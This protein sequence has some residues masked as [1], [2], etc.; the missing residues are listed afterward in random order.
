M[1]KEMRDRIREIPF[2][3]MAHEEASPLP[4][5]QKQKYPPPQPQH[6]PYQIS[7]ILKQNEDITAI[8]SSPSRSA[9]QAA[10]II[11]SQ[12]E[13]PLI[14]IQELREADI[15]LE[16]PLDFHRRVL[17][18]V[19]K[20]IN[21]PGPILIVSHA[22]IQQHLCTILNLSSKE[23]CNSGGED[24]L[25]FCSPPQAPLFLWE[26]SLLFDLRNQ[27]NHA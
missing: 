7:Q 22:C 23:L 12:L 20:A 10:E 26:S 19:N 27:I 24:F 18:G 16:T 21:R 4:R 3:F 17:N 15:P 8:C 13:C 6:G 14:P 5:R 1:R 2:Y 9:Y 25:L 11:Q